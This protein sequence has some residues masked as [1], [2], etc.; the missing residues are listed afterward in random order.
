MLTQKH[1][2]ESKDELVIVRKAS[3]LNVCELCFTSK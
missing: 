1:N 2:E 3:I